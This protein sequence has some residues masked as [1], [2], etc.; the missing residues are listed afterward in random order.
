MVPSAGWVMVKSASLEP[1]ALL[2]SLKAGHY[3][4][5]TGA[6]LHDIRLDGDRLHVTCSPASV[7][8]VSGEGSRTERV[9]PG[10]VESG[11]V[12]LASFRRGGWCRVTVVGTD[13]SRAWSNPIW[14]DAPG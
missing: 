7:I 9:V 11:S 5:S 8:I 12:P 1:D 2:A 3:Y 13:G 10:P 14:L 4:S 6:D